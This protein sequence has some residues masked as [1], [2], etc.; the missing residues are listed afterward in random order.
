ML[1][2]QGLRV[3]GRGDPWELGKGKELESDERLEDVGR[4]AETFIH[5]EP[6]CDFEPDMT[7]SIRAL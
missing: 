6:G 7:V 3:V 1:L 4:I 5:L 2:D